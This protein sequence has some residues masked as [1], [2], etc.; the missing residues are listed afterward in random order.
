MAMSSISKCFVR[1][2]MMA[3]PSP[4]GA[5]VIPRAGLLSVPEGPP[6]SELVTVGDGLKRVYL[7]YVFRE[8]VISPGL[9]AQGSAATGI[10][11]VA[12]PH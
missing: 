8:P 2:C 10:A 4:F 11:S 3:N 7:P 6:I 1:S 9:P 12:Q 5:R